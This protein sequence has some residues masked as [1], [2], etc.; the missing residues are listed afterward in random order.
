[1][2]KSPYRGHAGPRGVHAVIMC[3]DNDTGSF[4]NVSRDSYQ[5]G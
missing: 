4:F 3:L 2:T 1:M 5:V